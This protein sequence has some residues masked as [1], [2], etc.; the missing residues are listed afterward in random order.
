MNQI[1]I[2]PSHSTIIDLLPLSG[3]HPGL[4]HSWIIKIDM[5]QYDLNFCPLVDVT[6]P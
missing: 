4:I 2:L 3:L 6:L 1:K 5:E